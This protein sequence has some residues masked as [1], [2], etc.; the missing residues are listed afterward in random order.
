MK[1]IHLCLLFSL[2]LFTASS[3]KVYFV[4]IQTEGEQPFYVKINEKLNSSTATG[5]II[6]SKLLDSSYNLS[7]GFP[8]G[9]WPEQNFSVKVN[10]TDHGYLLK[11][12]GEKGWG[13]FDLQTMAMQMAITGNAST[14]QRPVMD[15][16]DI[17]PFTELLSKAADDPSLKEKPSIP[18]VEEKKPDV[19]VR[20]IPKEIIPEV[21]ASVATQQDK[22]DEKPV[23]KK[24][25]SRSKGN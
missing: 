7:I 2:S 6:L 10:K 8:Q 11:N 21:T 24:K 22:I 20:E 23:G 14:E 4:Y 3:Q 18:K 12:L 25:G 5:Y 19:A 17:S 1:K 16:K 15:S 13:L 9:K